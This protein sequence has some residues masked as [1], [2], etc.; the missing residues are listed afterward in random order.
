M[1]RSRLPGLARLLLRI[2]PLGDRRSEIEADL[3]E[4]FTERAASHNARY[5]RRRYYGDVLSL[6]RSRGTSNIQP[7]L[8]GVRP[9]LLREVVQDVSYALRMLRRTPA[10][11][12]VAVLG[13]GLAIGVGTA[14]FSLLN[15]AAFRSTGITDPSTSVRVL[16]AYQNGTGTSWHYS[17]F[18]QLRDGARGASLDAWLRDDAAVGFTANS[19]APRTMGVTFVTGSYLGRLNSRTTRGRLLL[20]SDD[21]SGSPP[22]VVI[23]YGLWHRTLA[24]DPAI[25]GRTLWLNGVAFTVVGV[26]AR[27]FTGMTASSPTI[28]APIG[29]YHLVTGGTA[30]DRNTALAVNV[31]G[32][33]DKDA[34]MAQSASALSAIA[35]ALP[36]ARLDSEGQPLTGVHLVATTD[37]VGREASGIALVAAIVVTVIGL[38]LLLACVNVTNLLLAAAVARQREFGVRLALGASRWRIVRQLMTE[39]VLFGIGGGVS[40]LLITVWLVPTLAS[41]AR[42]PASLD[43]DPDLRVYLFLAALSI[44]AGVGAGL[45]PARHAMR[46]RFAS[47]LKGLSAGNTAFSRSVSSRAVLVAVQAA[48]SLVLLV[49]AALLARGMVRA[50]QI[51]VGFDANRLLTVSPGFG[52]GGYDS[53]RAQAYWQVALERV[54]LLPGVRSASLADSPPF[55]EGARV[56]IFRRPDGRYTIYY[57]DTRAEFFTVVGLHTVRGRTYTAAE[58]AERAAV[59]VISEGLARDFFGLD[60]PVGQPLGRIIEDSK[61]T[62]IGVVSNAIT[63]RLRELGSATIYQ[64]MGQTV[65]AKMLVRTVG[66][67]E[68]LMPSVRAALQPLDPRA[69]LNIGLVADGLQRQIAEPRALA[70][71]AAFLAIIALAL[72][73]VGL[74]GVTAFIVGQRTQE[75]GLRIALGANGRDVMRL[76]LNDSLRPVLI[77]L[78]VGVVLALLGGRVFAGALYGV[79]SADPIAFV[80]AISV[81]AIAAVAAV[82]LPTRRASAVD[83]AAV[84]RQL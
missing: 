37:S 43:L 49:G 62:I 28:W 10:V 41:V 23:S 67:P 5:A 15:A 9:H 18:A 60:D 59:A 74:Y 65:G 42:A 19:D 77:G 3:L 35:V 34:S 73:A 29:S 82:I 58:V 13:L 4:L 14:V 22:V 31:V 52:R 2:V 76:L 45:V 38:V 70:T 32:R 8:P 39:S 47:P 33:L 36:E 48:V 61:A 21:P 66:P 72:A 44:V 64:P 51:D 25:I 26:A 30:V 55:G 11:V 80:S 1:S 6:W 17:D 50:T 20:P 12:T 63:A 40:G 24:A 57:N 69:Q 75:I 27:G 68:A 7:D 83:P 56:T 16:R 78:A 84:L 54:Q 79:P 81:L 71:V 53:A 46:D